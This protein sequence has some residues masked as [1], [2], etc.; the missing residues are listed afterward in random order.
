MTNATK[1][2][3]DVQRA[4][5]DGAAALS[6]V[7]ASWSRSSHLHS[8]SP[9]RDVLP[10][11]VEEAELQRDRDALGRLLEAARPS[12]DQIFELVGHAGCSV[13]MANNEGVILERRGKMADDAMFERGGLWTGTVWSE[14][15]QGT[16]AI[17]TSIVEE[18]PVVIYQDEHFL[19]RNTVLSCM[20]APIY[21]EYGTLAAVVDVSSCRPELSE[22]FARVICSLAVDAAHRIETQNF[23]LAFAGNRIVMLEAAKRAPTLLAIDKHDIVI[24]ATY[25]ARKVLGLPQIRK[26]NVPAPELFGQNP[27]ESDTFDG[28]ERGVL[29]RALE[30]HSRNMTQTAKALGLSRATLYRKLAQHGLLNDSEI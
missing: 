30:R 22:E 3:D 20:T 26:L 17:G 2:V 11:R 5:K 21:D 9:E 8:L 12:L 28:A 24:G 25:A 7:A 29:L 23:N 1:H 6:P 16:N 13:V 18:R 19:T 15:S 27:Q 4:L 10:Q 14:R